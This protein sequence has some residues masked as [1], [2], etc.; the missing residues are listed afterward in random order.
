M[1]ERLLRDGGEIQRV[2]AELHWGQR[3][4]IGWTEKTLRR[5]LEILQEEI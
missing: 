1:P 4:Q 3:A 2:L 5:E